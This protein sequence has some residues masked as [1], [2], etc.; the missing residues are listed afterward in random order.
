M[1]NNVVPL[2]SGWRQN[3]ALLQSWL[4]DGMA[5]ASKRS[6]RTLAGNALVG[7]GREQALQRIDDARSLL[8]SIDAEDEA[9]LRREFE[10]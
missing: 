4:R 1:K 7:V 8:L 9:Q 10:L 6:I 2:F 5:E 3:P